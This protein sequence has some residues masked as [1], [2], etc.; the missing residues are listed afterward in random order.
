MREKR[1][2]L[3]QIEFE[4]NQNNLTV[5][6]PCVNLN[7]TASTE[8]FKGSGLGAPTVE[9]QRQDSQDQSHITSQNHYLTQNPITNYDPLFNVTSQLSEPP[10]YLVASDCETLNAKPMQGNSNPDPLRESNM[11]VQQIL[12]NNNQIEQIMNRYENLCK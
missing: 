6:V 3:T 10:T 5:N 12:T 9:Y 7:Y 1:A 11:H 4:N 8:A 2:N